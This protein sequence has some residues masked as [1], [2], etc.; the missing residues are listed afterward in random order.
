MRGVLLSAVVSGL[1]FAQPVEVPVFTEAETKKLAAGET[2]VREVTPTD[3]RGVG[4][5][6][7]GVVDAPSTEVWP[8]LRDCA[9][10]DKFMP[11]IKA[12]A[13]NVEDGVP[14]CHVELSLP[15]PLMNLWSDTSSVE[16]EEPAGHFFREWTLV[17]GTYRRNGGAWLVVPWGAE[18][19]KTLVG[20]AI[21]S[22]P[23]ILIPDGI[24]RSA[25]TGSLPEVFAAIRKRVRSLSHR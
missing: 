4:V 5:Q 13:M 21:D 16:R 24:L 14:L 7:F 15:F 2:V 11:R 12:S 8:V 10:F 17:R 18:K 3:N 22:D 25:Q 20:Y 19:N 23:I 1:A 6:S 9:L